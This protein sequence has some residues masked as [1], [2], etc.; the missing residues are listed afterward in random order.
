VQTASVRSAHLRKAT[1]NLS[2]VVVSVVP[3]EKKTKELI[4]ASPSQADVE[5]HYHFPA[6]PRSQSLDQTEAG[7]VDG[8]S[9]VFEKFVV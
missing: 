1:E 4:E 6:I 5:H 8:V 3:K 7:C 2:S 9:L